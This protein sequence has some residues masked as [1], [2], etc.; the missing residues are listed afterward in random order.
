MKRIIESLPEEATPAQQDSA[1]QAHLPV[2]EKMRS[3]RPDTLNLPG[4]HI[5]SADVSQG[6][7]LIDYDESFFRST[8]YYRTELQY[9]ATGLAAEPVSYEL[10]NDDWVTGILIC[11]FLIAATILGNSKKFIKVQLQNFLLNREDKENLFTWETGQ[12]MRHAVYLHMQT[13]LLLSLFFFDYT[14]D[15]R[16]LFM[17]PISSH[18][19]LAIYILICW[20]YLG[21][22]QLSYRFVNWIYFDSKARRR[23]IKSYSFLISAE[24]ILFSPLALTMVFFNLSPNDMIFY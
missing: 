14:Q 10:R 20:L 2:R 7:S 12:E 13:G 16:D 11:C 24:G 9:H 19:L 22:K 15:T 17:T 6:A 1:V 18:I 4:W 3:E 21:F 23:W 5:P 8:P